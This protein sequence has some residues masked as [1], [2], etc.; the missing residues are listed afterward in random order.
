M[1][2]LYNLLD[3]YMGD[4]SLDEADSA[5]DR[6]VEIKAPG[7]GGQEGSKLLFAALQQFQ[8]SQLDMEQTQAGPPTK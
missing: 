3:P 1:A 7:Q 5:L 4:G 8:Q 2:S 6:A